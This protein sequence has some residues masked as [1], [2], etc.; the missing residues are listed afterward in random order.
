MGMVGAALLLSLLA[1]AGVVGA[2]QAPPAALAGLWFADNEQG[3]EDC[4]SF[5]AASDPWQNEGSLLVG[6]LWIDGERLHRMAE[7]GEGDIHQVLGSVD[8]SPTQWQ[9]DV[10]VGVDTLPDHEHD[11]RF[12]LQLTL[13]DGVLVWQEQQL[14]PLTRRWRRCSDTPSRNSID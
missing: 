2:W 10:V 3:Q 11:M 5:K 4:D 14:P 7:L 12:P 13:S 8:I 6:A 9:L 1:S